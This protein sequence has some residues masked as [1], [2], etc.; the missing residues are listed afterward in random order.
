MLEELSDDYLSS[1]KKYAAWI[2]RV[3]QVG[4]GLVELAAPRSIWNL[5]FR[6]W[7]KL[8]Y[9]IELI[10]V[11]GGT[12]LMRPTLQQF[13]LL[14]FGLTVAVHFAVGLLNDLM[15]SRRRWLNLLKT[16]LITLLLVVIVVG[17]ASV[18]GLVGQ[19]S[20]WGRMVQI[21]HW[22][23]QPSGLRTWS[24]TALV[25]LFFLA[26]IRGDFRKAGSRV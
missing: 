19:P 11:A 12:I 3:G 24:L 10:L 5:L 8:L 14:L 13:G 18:A 16:V 15:R 25:G 9:L 26:S 4:W 22:F 23:T 7:L 20:V 2:T 17:V 21:N 6:Y 1:G